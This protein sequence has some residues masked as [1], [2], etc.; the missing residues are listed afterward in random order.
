MECPTRV[1]DAN[2]VIMGHL[3]DVEAHVDEVTN[4]II[5]ITAGRDNDRQRGSPRVRDQEI[6]EGESGA[7]R[8]PPPADR[9]PPAVYDTII[10]I[11]ARKRME[12][13]AE[14]FLEA[15][16]FPLKRLTELNKFE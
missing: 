5:D 7:V 11:T 4:N 14:Q 9:R 1:F 15:F 10:Q 16:H 3:K 8:R 13:K 2:M 12:I 6:S